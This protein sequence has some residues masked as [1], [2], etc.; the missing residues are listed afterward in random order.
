MQDLSDIIIQKQQQN[1]RT[2][3][4]F[5]TDSLWA[6][7][8]AFPKLQNCIGSDLDKHEGTDFVHNDLRL[9]ATLDFDGKKFVP[10]QFDTG[11]PATSFANFK[12]G[13]RIGNDHNGYT[14]FP[15]PVVVIGLTMDSHTYRCC[16]DEIVE[17]MV[18]HA[19]D[20][21]FAANDAYLDYTTQDQEERDELF[22]QPLRPNKNFVAP[23]GMSDRYAE[24]NELQNQIMN[25][26]ET[27]EDYE[28][29]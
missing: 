8:K 10:F 29:D 18:K 24:L 11:I 2:G 16:Q 26:K 28:Y 6:L 13:I 14:E 23:K 25:S 12:M 19:D 3:S 21:M 9:D 22:S 1:T 15:E 4:E 17:N 5:E 20:L 27:G 7:Q